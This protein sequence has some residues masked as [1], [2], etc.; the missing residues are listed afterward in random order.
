V[1]RKGDETL[2]ANGLSEKLMFKRYLAEL[3]DEEA[4]RP[5]SGAT[6][7]DPRLSPAWAGLKLSV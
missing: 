5:P 1:R 3:L 4:R 2:A 7:F 6:G